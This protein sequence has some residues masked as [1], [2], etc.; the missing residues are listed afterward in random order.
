MLEYHPKIFQ[1]LCRFFSFFIINK[2][3]DAVAN[4]VYFTQYKVKQVC[5]DKKRRTNINFCGSD[6]IRENAFT[7]DFS[8]LLKNHFEC[9]FVNSERSLQ[10]RENRYTGYIYWIYPVYVQIPVLAI[11]IIQK[12]RYTELSVFHCVIPFA[13]LKHYFKSNLH[14]L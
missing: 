7:L 2:N 3:F 8:S 6:S 12:Y 10:S 13:G 1:N 5:A 11:C 9:L 14:C 4:A